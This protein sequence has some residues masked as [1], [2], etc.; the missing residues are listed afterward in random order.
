MV[1]LTINIKGGVQLSNRVSHYQSV[2]KKRNKKTQNTENADSYGFANF[3]EK[4]LRPL[5]PGLVNLLTAHN[6]DTI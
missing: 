1:L 3:L 2:Y 4:L 5:L 6:L